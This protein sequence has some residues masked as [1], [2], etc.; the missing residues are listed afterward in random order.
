VVYPLANLLATDQ[1][2]L[3]DVISI[4]W[5]RAAGNL[6]FLKEAEG[7]LVPMP[8]P[9]ATATAAAAAAHTGRAVPFVKTIAA[10]ERELIR[11]TR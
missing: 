10:G 9:D 11:P 6:L 1:V 3:G 2:A 8:A 5:N 7:A 4:D